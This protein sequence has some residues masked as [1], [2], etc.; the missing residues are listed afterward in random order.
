MNSACTAF[1]I[2]R[3]NETEGGNGSI[4]RSRSGSKDGGDKSH[5]VSVNFLL[6]PHSL[7][8]TEAAQHTRPLNFENRSYVL[9]ADGENLRTSLKLRFPK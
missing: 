3:V 7:Q 9:D 1:A 4:Y 6:A 5:I 8:Y 2:F